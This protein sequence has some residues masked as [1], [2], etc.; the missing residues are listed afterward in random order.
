MLA[1]QTYEVAWAFESSNNFGDLE[2]LNLS[3]NNSCAGGAAA[4]GKEESG[5][6]KGKSGGWEPDVRRGSFSRS[7]QI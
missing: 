1:M 7:P 5:H 3:F 4:D 2:L 6:G